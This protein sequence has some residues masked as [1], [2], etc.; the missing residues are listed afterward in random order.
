[1][2]LD[3]AYTD[4]RALV[5]QLE[6]LLGARVHRVKVRRVDLVEA[7]TTVEVRLAL[8]DAPPDLAGRILEPVAGGAMSAALVA[9]G[10][11]P[12]AGR[13]EPLA[14]RLQQL[15]PIELPEL[16]STAAL[17]TRRDRKYVVPVGVAETLVGLLANW[18]RALEVGGR[19][20][21]QYESVYFDTPGRT[22]CLDAARRRSRRFK[23]PHGSEHNDPHGPN[24]RCQP[25]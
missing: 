17:L 19:R 21:I 18:S 22:S 13:S 9:S 15:V 4:E 23:V 5:A 11:E 3:D 2:T 12:L 1:M 16:E 14:G 6:Q 25:T 10:S 8:L 7:T 24:R 20:R